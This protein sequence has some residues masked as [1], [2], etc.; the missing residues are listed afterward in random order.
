MQRRALLA[1]FGTASIGLL[2][3]CLGGN[4]PNSAYEVAHTEYVDETVTNDRPVDFSARVIGGNYES[5]T[6][7]VT[8]KLG[9]ENISENTWHFQS[10]T[11]WIGGFP[12]PNDE[13]HFFIF[14][15]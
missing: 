6:A 13:R 1:A 14:S 3:G 2:T 9:V 7:P 10:W 12:T 5:G 4:L 11:G 8:L 15:T